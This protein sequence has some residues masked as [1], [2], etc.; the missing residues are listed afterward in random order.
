MLSEPAGNLPA[1]GPVTRSGMRMSMKRYAGWWPL[2]V[3]V[4]AAAAAAVNDLGSGWVQLG[5][6]ALSAVALAVS[7]PAVRQWL[8]ALLARS[9]SQAATAQALLAQ[10]PGL[11]LYYAL[12]FAAIVSL[13]EMAFWTYKKLSHN[14]VLGFQFLWQI[15]LG[16]AMI[17][18]AVGLAFALVGRRLPR[19]GLLPG[20]LGT[21][22]FIGVAGWLLLVKEIHDV[23]AAVLAAGAAVQLA[24][25]LSAHGHLIHLVVRRTAPW[26][27][28]LVLGLAG[29]SFAHPR[30]TEYRA[31]AQLP[32]VAAPSP[33]VL[34]I[35]LDTVRA[36]SLSLYGYGRATTPNLDRFAA[37]GVVFDRALSTSPWTLPSHGGMFTGRFPHELSGD[38]MVPIDDTHP[39]LAEALGTRGYLTAGFIANTTFCGAEFGL[40]RGFAHYEDHRASL[41]SVLKSTSIGGVTLQTTQLPQAFGTQSRAGLK[42]A[43]A[44]NDSFLRWL[45]QQEPGRPFFAFLNY[46]DAHAPYALPDQVAPRFSTTRPRGD[47]W[48]RRLDAWQPHEVQELNDAYD[49][50]IAQ[51]DHDLG[52]LLEELERRGTLD[53]T[54]VI[55]TAN[56]GEQFGEHGLLEHANSLYLPLLHV[57]LVV[58]YPG[59]V[60]AGRRV[61]AMVSLRDL[62]ATVL[63]LAAV[64]GPVAFPGKSLAATWGPDGDRGA[65]DVLLAEVEQAYDAYPDSYPA[66]KGRMKSVFADGMHYIRNYG[67]K[68]EELYDLKSDWGEQRDV[69]A[70]DP[71]RA[72]GFREHLQRLLKAPVK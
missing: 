15:P 11:F 21:I 26:L 69:L 12:W 50:A 49:E 13:G 10:R 58:V 18:G 65:D 31:M 8:T 34:F 16:Y 17:F 43:V 2:A 63:E 54:L 35:V 64:S 60:P 4:A 71:A 61:E 33:N 32:P 38:W 46:Y 70:A 45:E 67:D 5:L 28:L 55:V 7:P 48:S 66:R 52:T 1:E 72:D 3:A 14:S 37:R 36:E 9:R 6:M 47:I 68:R 30:W 57:P 25:G 27:A 41:G 29:T 59:H 24:R 56:H 51:L 22:A 62:P 20:F 40:A 39:T 53:D 19:L 23:A 44:V 42:D